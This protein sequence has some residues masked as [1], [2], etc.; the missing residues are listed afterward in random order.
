MGVLSSYKM[1][2]H[3]VKKTCLDL[4]E[5]TFPNFYHHFRFI[6]CLVI[7]YLTS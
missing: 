1:G 3:A 7:T 2:W 4:E 5:Q 6:T